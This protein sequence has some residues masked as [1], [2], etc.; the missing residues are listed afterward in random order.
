MFPGNL[1]YVNV[2]QFDFFLHLTE[3]I[4][5]P[6]ITKL[7]SYRSKFW[8]RKNDPRYLSVLATFVLKSIWIH[9][10]EIVENRCRFL[11]KFDLR[12]SSNGKHF[13]GII[14]DFLTPYC[15]IIRK[16]MFVELLSTFLRHPL[17]DVV[18]E[19]SINNA[20]FTLS[21]IRAFKLST[22]WNFCTQW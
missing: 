14:D 10:T 15:R 3:A 17:A 6:E 13:L 1:L 19:Y 9:K 5:T 18:C 22:G 20:Y 11:K 21:H 8:F 2:W 16:E 4:K 12:Y 7:V